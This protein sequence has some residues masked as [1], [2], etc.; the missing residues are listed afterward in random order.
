MVVL[1][2]TDW[3][4]LQKKRAFT[5]SANALIHTKPNLPLKTLFK[6]VPEPIR[7]FSLIPVLKSL[8]FVSISKLK[9]K[10]GN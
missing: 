7:K 3:G 5:Y 2:N 10:M 4:N 8:L 1:N 9:R 6:R